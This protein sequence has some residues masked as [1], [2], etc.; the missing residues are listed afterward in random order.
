MCNIVVTSH[1]EQQKYKT[2]FNLEVA[3]AQW[4]HDMSANKN[5]TSEATNSWHVV[6]LELDIYITKASPMVQAI[7]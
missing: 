2:W 7:T 3:R 1:V 6:Q 4:Q 5:M